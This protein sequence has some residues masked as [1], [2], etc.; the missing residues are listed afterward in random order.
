MMRLPGKIAIITGAAAGIGRASALLFAREGAKVAA[1]DMDDGGIQTLAQDVG[2]AG[3]EALAIRADVSKAEEVQRVVR[4]ALDRFGRL[5]ILFN[6]VGIVPRGKVHTMTEAEWD[7]TMTINVKS[8][9]LLCRE[10]IPVFL[11]QGGGVILNT[12]S[13]T[14]LRSVPDR[15]AYST[16]KGA[17][18]ALTRSMAVDYVKDHIRVNCLCPGTVDTPSFRQRMAAF[19]DPEEALRQFVARQPMGRLG[20]A[21]EVAQAALYLVSDD[22]QF[23]TGAA[24]AI[25]GGMTI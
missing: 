5:D 25:D 13:A 20:T 23:V 15:V 12:S 1:V 6:N 14:A 8:M 10:V 24:F 19:P 18:L 17:V 16:S 3:G 11:K 2:A 4:F 22:A 7:R 21:D 9:Y